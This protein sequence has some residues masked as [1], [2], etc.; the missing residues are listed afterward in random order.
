MSDEKM[1]DLEDTV[2]ALDRALAEMRTAV[3][4]SYI[5]IFL[6]AM[7]MTTWICKKNAEAYIKSNQ[8]VE[9]IRK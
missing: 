8:P 3:R 5:L 7:L 6:V 1:K 4:V 2:I 9:I